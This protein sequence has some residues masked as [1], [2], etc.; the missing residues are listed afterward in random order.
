M[1]PVSA[2][3]SRKLLARSFEANDVIVIAESGRGAKVSSQS[4]PG[5][6]HIVFADGT[7]DCKAQELGR[8]CRHATR[9]A[10][11]IQRLRRAEQFDQQFK[12]AS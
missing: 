7:C 6:F 11:E 2:E 5:R 8:P 12:F 10:W 9:F 4:E 1:F 3:H